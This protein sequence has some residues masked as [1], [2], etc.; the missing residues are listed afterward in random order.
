MISDGHRASEVIDGIRALFRKG[1]QG[2]QR[3][4]VNAIVHAVLQSLR[5]ELKDHGVENR[6]E[7]SE[8]PL[9]DGHRGQ[10]Q[11]VVFNLV[12][13]AIEAMDTMQDRRR[14]LRVRTEPLGHEAIVLTVEDSGPGIVPQQLDNIFDAFVTTK[15]HGMG[16]GLA[17]SRMIV[18]HHGGKLAASSDGKSGASFQLVLPTHVK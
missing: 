1:D 12:Q 10:L 14:I 11:E 13:N 4:D 17:I 5:G 9:V 15:S 7:L 8:L 3:V 18:E 16:L 2:R 6:L